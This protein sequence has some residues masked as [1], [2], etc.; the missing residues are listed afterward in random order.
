MRIA[1]AVWRQM[2]TFDQP[3]LESIAAK[4]HP[5][6]FERPE[7]L[8]EKQSLYRPGASLLEIGERP[9]GYVLSHPW[10]TGN[11]PKLDTLLGALPADPDTYYIHDLAL[12]PVARRIGAA[13]QILAALEKHASALELPTI[14]LVAVNNSQPYWEKQGFAV[15]EDPALEAELLGY[16]AAARYMVKPLV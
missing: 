5:G 1:E 10:R 11:L 8:A 7:V 3:A 14:S 16:E 13:A 15:A 6:F 9:T 4:V 12:L 2:T